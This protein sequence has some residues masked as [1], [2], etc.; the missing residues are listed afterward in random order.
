MIPPEDIADGRAIAVA[1][2]RNPD[3]KRMIKSAPPPRA[4]ANRREQDLEKV[5]RKRARE[6]MK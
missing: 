1:L 4:T 2:T 6:S 5:N 3:A